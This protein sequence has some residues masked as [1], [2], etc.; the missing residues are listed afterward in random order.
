MKIV[1]LFLGFCVFLQLVLIAKTQRDLRATHETQ[2]KRHTSTQTT[3]SLNK[4]SPS[5]VG[6]GSNVFYYRPHDPALNHLPQRYSEE[7]G[8]S[9]PGEEFI[10]HLGNHH[11]YRT[12]KPF[13]VTHATENYQWTAEDGRSPEVMKQLANNSQMYDELERTNSFV[14]D[15]SL[16]YVADGFGERVEGIFDGS[17]EEIVLPGPDGKEFKVKITQFVGDETDA[18]A[19]I[20]GAFTGTIDGQPDSIIRGASQEDYWSIGITTQEGK[21]YE[22]INRE[23]G[24]WILSAIDQDARAEHDNFG[25]G[26]IFSDIDTGSPITPENQYGNTNN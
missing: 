24:E 12:P 3:S 17:L 10:D 4:L 9:A 18:G 1:I 14:T 25:C 13:K 23:H 22:I 19:Q 8:A 21:N 26:S 11:W 5:M 7:V 20:T 2:Q 15:R 16:I 6:P